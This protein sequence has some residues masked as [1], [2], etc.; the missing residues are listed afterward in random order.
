MD[1]V[2]ATNYKESQIQ[3]CAYG[4]NSPIRK[5]LQVTHAFMPF[6]PPL[7]QQA[8]QTIIFS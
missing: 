6:S 5:S 4:D 1:I 7:G 8:D 3:V 2:S